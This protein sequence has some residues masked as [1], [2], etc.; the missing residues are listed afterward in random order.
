MALT[1]EGAAKQNL[2]QGT[3]NA[4]GESLDF[5]LYDTQKLAN[6]TNE[7][8]F[9]TQ[10][11]GK[12]FTIG[13]NKTKADS[14]IVADVIPSG[15]RLMVYVVE[16]YVQFGVAP[17][18]ETV[19][20]KMLGLLAETVLT[21]NIEGKDRILQ[22]TVQQLMGNYFSGIVLQAAAVNENIILPFFSKIEPYILKKPI[23]LASLTHFEG[24]MIHYV[25][26]DAA[27]NNFKLKFALRGKFERLS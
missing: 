8:T 10:G 4:A 15:Q 22:R 5:T 13:G 27:L 12:P 18:D 2:E 25:T 26:P 14:N 9:F 6:G 20:G 17:I 19:I 3:H 11:N 1:P 21:I 16:T 7:H 24:N 23:P